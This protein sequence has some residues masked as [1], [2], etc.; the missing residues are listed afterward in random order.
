MRE[1]GVRS[2]VAPTRRATSARTMLNLTHRDG[3]ETP[4]PLVAGHR[5]QVRIQLNDAGAVFPAGHKVR[6]A[7]STTYWPMI[8]PSPQIA[9]L[10]IFGG[11]LEL[12][13]RPPRAADDLPPLPDVETAAPE[14]PTMVRPGLVRIDRIGVELGSEYSSNYD[15]KEDDPLSAV[16]ETR[17]VQTVSRDSWQVRTETQMRLSCTRDAFLLRAELRAWEGGREVCHRTWDCTIPRD[18]V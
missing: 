8:W 14:R 9:T 1:S 17:R 10:T 2:A 4:S 3:H 18:L 11:A 6:L 13:V 12:P 15:I 16:A 7:L 5:Y